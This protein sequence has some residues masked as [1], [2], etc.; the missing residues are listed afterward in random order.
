[1]LTFGTSNPMTQKSLC[2][3]GFVLGAGLLS[4]P[5]TATQFVLTYTGTV[6]AA[7]SLTSAGGPDLITSDTPFTFTALFDNATP[8]IVAPLPR[9]GP[10]NGFVAYVPSQ[11]DF[12][13][14]GIQYALTG[15]G[16]G[17]GPTIA[18]LDRS[19]IFNPNRYGIGLI[20]NPLADGAGFIG[21]FLSAS[22]DFSVGA[23]SSTTF[24]NFAGAGFSAGIGCGPDPALCTFQPLSLTSGGQSYG[25][26]FAGTL[27]AVDG[28]VSYN[29]GT[30]TASLR[31]VPEPATWA[32][33]LVGFGAVGYRMR[34]RTRVLALLAA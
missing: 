33:M 15:L 21:D 20:V 16:N 18:I 13:I 28:G 22:P 5:A 4:A 23:L 24:Q 9:P 7:D 3:L 30:A 12:T 26:Q 29:G 25:L 8:N 6:H 2:A 31:A 32:M 11:A 19:N 1:M 34:R 14:G 17:A 10:G 27:G